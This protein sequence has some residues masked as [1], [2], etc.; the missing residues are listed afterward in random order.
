MAP[1]STLLPPTPSC[2]PSA[3]GALRFCTLRVSRGSEIRTH[4]FHG[5]NVISLPVG[6]RPHVPY[7]ER[8]RL[9]VAQPGHHTATTCLCWGSRGRD[10]RADPAGLK[11]AAS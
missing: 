5:L 4:T 11:P 9:W 8:W 6:V 2:G 10:P 7:A 3:V 1:Q